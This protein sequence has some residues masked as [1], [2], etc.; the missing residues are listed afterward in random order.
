MCA[1]SNHLYQIDFG[2]ARHF[3]PGQIKD[4]MPFGSPGYAAPEQYG[5]AQTTQQS[6][7]YSL[8]VL[9]HHLLSGEDP[10]EKPFLLSPLRLYG[11]E[12]LIKLE[13]LIICMSDLNPEQ[14]PKSVAEVQ[15]ELRDIATLSTGNRVSLQPQGSPRD[16]ARTTDREHSGG[17][18]ELV[19]E[20]PVNRSRRRFV[21]GGL[22]TGAALVAG[23]GSYLAL[24]PKPRVKIVHPVPPI[25][26]VLPAPDVMFGF[27]AKHTRFNATE[28]I[29]SPANVSQLKVSWISPP[30][31]NIG[32]SPTVSASAVYVGSDDGRL[33]AFDAVTGKPRWVSVSIG[34]Y[35]SDS[36]LIAN[37]VIYV[38]SGNDS[39][40]ALDATTGSTLWMSPPTSGQI[41]TQPAVAN[42]MV[43]DASADNNGA[44]NGK[45]YA[46]HLPDTKN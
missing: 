30:I 20:P 14:R 7:I 35:N 36:P 32:S 33:Y 9:L 17:R 4:T 11:P 25:K 15:A 13:N 45:I 44:G 19:F 31:G 43:Y 2:I 28:K 6:D 22:I 1:P 18:Q 26:P 23:V 41:F 24:L 38:S 16:E 10:S 40:Y 29:L 46:F 3:K 8:G 12:E 5:K 39:V 27:D 21:I 34:A 42:G 37:G